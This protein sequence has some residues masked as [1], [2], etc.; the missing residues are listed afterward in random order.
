MQKDKLKNIKRNINRYTP[1]TERTIKEQEKK[2]SD[3]LGRDKEG[4][5]KWLIRGQLNWEREQIIIDTE[6]EG[7][8]TNGFQKM[9]D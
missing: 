3:G 8:H 7:H 4:S 5:L 6:D 1:T 9:A 2:K